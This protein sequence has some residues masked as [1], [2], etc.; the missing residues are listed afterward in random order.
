MPT[1]EEL[2]IAYRD[3]VSAGAKAGA[4]AL[5]KLADA[6][7]TTDARITRSGRTAT[8]YV[9]SL[10]GVTKSFRALNKA[11]SDL[12]DMQ[13]KLDAAVQSG[14]VT[15]DQ[16]TRAIDAQRAK[17]DAL[18]ARHEASVS[19][20][21][22]STAAVRESTEVARV[23]GYQLGILADEAHK[24]F[25]QIMA[26]GSAVT[27]AFYQLPNAVQVMGG[28]RTS[29]QLAA[30]F[31][32][33]PGGLAVGAL[34][35]GAAI[36]KM[37]SYAESEARQLDTL[38]Q[39]LRATRDDYDAMG[40]SA[41]EAAQKIAA[42]SGLSVSD[43]RGVSS[44]FAA[45][46]TVG[47]S[48][49]VGLATEARD[50]ATVLGTEVPEAAR[51]MADAYADPS[52][53]AEEFAQQ[54]LL[55]VHESLVHQIEDMQ[56]SGSRMGAWRL[57]M[58]Q[59][60]DA[61][62]G[63][64]DQGMTPL[65]ASLHELDLAFNGSVNGAKSFAQWIGDGIRSEAADTVNELTALV[66]VVNRLR[67][68]SV[69]GEMAASSSYSS[70]LSD[71]I[72]QIGRNIGANSDVVSLAQRIQ[73]IESSSGQFDASG[74]VVRSSRGALGAMQVMP[75]N[76]NGND[77]N[78]VDGNITASEQLL[79]HLYDKYR[80]NQALVAMAYNWG[81]GHVDDYLSRKINTVPQ[82]VQDYAQQVTGGQIYSASSIA[83]RRSL[84]DD[85]L[86]TSDG[87]TSA[88]IDT[89]KQAIG[90]LS[91]AQQALNDLR[92]VGKISDSDYAAQTQELTQRLNEHRGALNGLRD[93]LQDI[94]HSQGLAAQSAA[95][96]TAAEAAMVQVDQQVEEAARRMGQQHATAA[97]LAAA[98]ARQQGILTDQFNSSVAA[99]NEKTAAQS[100]MIAG[101]D[102]TKGPLTAYLNAEQ[103]GEQV[104]STSIDDTAE[105]ARQT[106]ILTGALNSASQAQ[107]D[108]ATT[109]K[110]YGQ[111]Q[112]LEFIQAETNAIGQNS[113]AVAVSLA[114]LRERQSLLAAGADISSAASKA[115]L[116]N[117]AAIQSATNAYEHQKQVLSDVTGSISS[118]AD[119]IGDDLTQAFIQGSGSAVSFKSA[120]QG[121][122]TQVVS[123]V[124]RLALINPMLNDIDGGTRS[125]LS[126][127]GS[128]LS[129]SGRSTGSI[130]IPTTSSGG[131]L[132]DPFGASGSA[133]VIPVDSS[134][135][136]PFSGSGVNAGSSFSAGNYGA[137]SWGSILGG[138]AGG[139]GLGSGL[140]SMINSHHQLGSTA[141]SAVGAGAG[142]AIG[143]V[144]P[145]VGTVIG[146]LVG[147]LFGGG[148]GSLF[149]GHKKNPYT[150]DQVMVGDEGFSLGQTWN[151]AQDDQITKQLS[152]DITSL[153]SMLKTYGLSATGGYIG[154]VRDDQNNKDASLRSVSLD[155]LLSRVGLHS[156]DAT[157]DQALSQGMP[158][159][160]DSVSSF[161]SA[162]SQLKTMA[163]TV[164]QLG[165]SVSRFNS[166]GTVTV[167]DFA[168]A[169]G[170]LRTALEHVLDGKTVSTSDL[171]TQISTITTFVGTT[172]PN[173]LSATVDGQQSWVD[174][175]AALRSTYDAAASQAS[176]Y[177]LDGD[178]VT[179]KFSSLY[180][181]GYD[182]NMTS[183]G[184]SDQ[185]V[186]ARYLSATGD[187]TTADL[188]NFDVSARQ[189]VQQLQDNW[190]AF[191]GSSY[192]S[193][194]TYAA[195]MTDLER[196]LAAERLKIEQTYSDQ[197]R[198][199][200]TS[201]FG[202][203]TSYGRGLVLSDASPF[204]VQEQYGV[205]NDNIQND[206]EK[207]MD[208]DSD[209][210]SRIRDEAQDFLSLSQKWNGSG[211]GYASDFSKVTDMLSNLGSMNADALTASLAKQL[212]GDQLS[213]LQ[214]LLNQMAD[215]KQVAQ[216]I[217]S[218]QKL[219]QV[220]D[221]TRPRAA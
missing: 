42:Q 150:I 115:D 94:A 58:A 181:Q 24:F 112:T 160:F 16:A 206:Y 22:A 127:V 29:V 196:T 8:G 138:V 199:S 137:A 99:I 36:Y 62:R 149:G 194:Q 93:P 175:M 13:T 116:D 18:T 209:A 109:S 204:S 56:A 158:A 210:L 59:M 168:S 205:A 68:V 50:L 198:Q 1:V 172:M 165:V 31:L 55:G 201:V 147:G 2:E 155:D 190:E 183:L 167:K 32:A 193:N 72:D 111:S 95:T 10:D 52:K 80:G 89:Q 4:E 5:N 114:V 100:R 57:L 220:T 46:P 49:L 145:V 43:S 170:D 117:V 30:S 178:A 67:G 143:S 97:Q 113:D 211:A 182:K 189:Q 26:G 164:E 108:L 126:D 78:T 69:P 12:A 124:A 212:S 28:F 180:Q 186:Q 139:V 166:D 128:L 20:T 135:Y 146:G 132:F 203:L 48:D 173:L 37:G 169:T 179:S 41:T 27:A 92:A 7:E 73:P 171:Q 140:G 74:A 177:G 152:S 11:Q 51:K 35:A 21:Q 162:V 151:Q 213:V 103:A 75:S 53:A 141:G 192:A 136:D 101:Y 161:Q 133:S 129:G 90:Q 121:I 144:F 44:T 9:N 188:L 64:A 184:D 122:E 85:S 200:L 102:A 14:T 207:A 118:M 125:T 91:A 163:D 159:S 214:Q 54:G 174:Q 131:S 82:S 195:Q 86:R 76:A 61:A 185:S 219:Q 105:Q 47:G 148:L 87:S 84:V 38:S 66:N 17:V 98:E 60:G 153:N 88:Q 187:Q 45:I 15:Q 221:S 71:R 3:Q 191:L 119:T 197:A 208:G 40:R 156:S 79:V 106:V 39:H 6:A 130:G 107:A 142:A 134:S 120:M 176:S 70:S 202:D 63:A 217:Q 96:Y 33:G 123:L 154:T 19:A 110:L 34:A 25:D 81:E 215:L 65:Q 104:R 157:F 216:Q 23:S 77:L 218:T 83:G